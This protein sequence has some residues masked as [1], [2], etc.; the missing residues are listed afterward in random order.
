MGKLIAETIRTVN[1]NGIQDE[2]KAKVW[3]KQYILKIDKKCAYKSDRYDNHV[4]L[5]AKR[6]GTGCVVTFRSRKE[7]NSEG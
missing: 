3:A 4:I 6:K 5:S 2:L 1:V 7:L